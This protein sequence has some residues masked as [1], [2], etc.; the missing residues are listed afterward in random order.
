MFGTCIWFYR[1]S[2][3]ERISRPFSPTLKIKNSGSPPPALGSL[4]GGGRGGSIY[5]GVRFNEPKVG[6]LASAAF[7]RQISPDIPDSQ[8]SQ[9]A[10]LD[11]ICMKPSERNITQC[12]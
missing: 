4:P 5:S 2:E 8:A 12:S 11:S 9:K 7:H 1:H 6:G 10:H 3:L